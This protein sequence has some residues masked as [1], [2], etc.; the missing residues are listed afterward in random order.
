[1]PVS[2]ITGRTR[3]ILVGTLSGLNTSYSISAPES[4]APPSA[5]IGTPSTPTG[6]TLWLFN[7]IQTVSLSKTLG[8]VPIETFFL[9]LSIFAFSF[10]IFSLSALIFSNFSFRASF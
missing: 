2:G 6:S 4:A 10:S 9:I 8:L 3:G 7:L 1:M 5:G